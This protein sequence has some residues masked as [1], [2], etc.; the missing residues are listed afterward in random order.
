MSDPSYFSPLS[1][2]HQATWQQLEVAAQQNEKQQQL[3]P[4]VQAMRTCFPGFEYGVTINAYS[5]LPCLLSD[6]PTEQDSDAWH[7]EQERLSE[8]GRNKQ[9]YGFPLP[10]QFYI[11]E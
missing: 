2:G 11:S 3:R 5:Y 4:Y 9:T 10:M 8:P 1:L 6:P 7:Q